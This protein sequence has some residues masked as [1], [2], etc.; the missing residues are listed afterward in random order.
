MSAAK[1]AADL[2]HQ[3]ARD[4]TVTIPP[5]RARVRGTRRIT[6]AHLGLWKVP[7]PF[8]E[9]IVLAVSELVTNGIA[10]GHGEIELKVSYA[11]GDL[12]VEVTDDSS[13]PARLT[14]AEDDDVSGRGLFLVAV[15]A[16]NW[17]V[18]NAGRT[19]WCVFRI[20]ARRL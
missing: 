7:L 2:Q 1:V 10:H 11:D 16:Q 3:A 12:R 4:F 8:A 17:G 6:E 19:T 14:V 13:T 20:P 5:D 9:H 18:S 15:L